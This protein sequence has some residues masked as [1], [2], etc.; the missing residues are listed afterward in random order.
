VLYYLA[1]NLD[2]GA[3]RFVDRLR[4]GT[5]ADE[6]A[7][8]REVDV[9]VRRLFTYAAWADKWD[10]AVKSVPVRGVVLGMHEPWG[11]AAVSCPDEAPLLAFVSLVAPLLA[12]GNRVIATPSPRAPLAALDLVHVV[13]AS[14]VPAGALNV[15]TGD[16]DALAATLA[17]HEEV[18]VHWYVGSAAGSADVERRSAGNLKATWVNGGRKRDWYDPAHAEGRPFLRRAVQVKSVW[19]PYGA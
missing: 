10:G 9:S 13:E 4:D 17:D 8:R 14:D 1:E 18:A 6:A 15:I 11:V 7:A 2:A 3:G 12:M 5:G 19:V 16:R